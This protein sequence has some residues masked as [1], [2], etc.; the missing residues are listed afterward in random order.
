MAEEESRHRGRDVI[1][2]TTTEPIERHWDP[3]IT[4]RLAWHERTVYTSCLSS[5]GTGPSG[6]AG[7]LRAYE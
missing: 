3:T 4:P 6:H 5:D 1:I 2:I 7:G